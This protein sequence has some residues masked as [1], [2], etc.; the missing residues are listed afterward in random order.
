VKDR[1][2]RG[3]DEFREAYILL[4]H[5]RFTAVLHT[6]RNSEEPDSPWSYIT[7]FRK[8][9][10]LPTREEVIAALRPVF[11]PTVELESD[12][13]DGGDDWIRVD[14]VPGSKWGFRFTLGP[15]PYDPK[16]P[17]DP[18]DH[19][20]LRYYLEP[21]EETST[22]LLDDIPGIELD[23]GYIL[24]IQPV[25]RVEELK[26]WLREQ[27]L[28]PPEEIEAPDGSTLLAHSFEVLNRFDR[29]LPHPKVRADIDDHVSR[30]IGEYA[31]QT[32]LYRFPKGQ[33]PY[34][35]WEDLPVGAVVHS[36]DGKVLK[37][38]EHRRNDLEP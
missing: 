25:E 13:V 32:V 20:A 18:N 15:L 35:T 14:P 21:A 27:G 5:Q 26:D 30:A 4:D 7:C 24:T 36:P 29:A 3:D 1:I 37:V 12:N 9:H 34:P 8:D 19:F 11:R 2:D 31:L 6:E 23:Y 28:P 16:D 22:L 17:R 10:A 33:N 38:P